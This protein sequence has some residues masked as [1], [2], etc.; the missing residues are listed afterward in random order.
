MQTIDSK[1]G[2]FKQRKKVLE[3]DSVAYRIGRRLENQAQKGSEGVGGNSPAPH[4]LPPRTGCEDCAQ[5]PP[6]CLGLSTPPASQEFPCSLSLCLM[7][8]FQVQGGS[9]GMWVQPASPS[10]GSEGRSR[11][12]CRP[13][14]WAASSC[15]SFLT[16]CLD[17]GKERGEIPSTNTFLSLLPACLVHVGWPREGHIDSACQSGP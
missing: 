14:R 15:L 17:L 13:S 16:G 12:A 5:G 3:G 1:D 9:A 11:C 6:H 10:L 7:P 2:S 8:Q 4:P